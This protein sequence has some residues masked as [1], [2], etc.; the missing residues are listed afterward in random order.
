MPEAAAKSDMSIQI[1]IVPPQL[2]PLTFGDCFQ[3]RQQESGAGNWL[4]DWGLFA[5]KCL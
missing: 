3:S 4:W 2:P 1:F 5:V